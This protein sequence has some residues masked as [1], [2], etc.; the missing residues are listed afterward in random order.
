MQKGTTFVSYL[1]WLHEY[2]TTILAMVVTPD[3]PFVLI[4]D[5]HVSRYHVEALVFARYNGIRE[6]GK[7]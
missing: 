2:L 7:R 1:R 6:G 3:M 4:L 5:G